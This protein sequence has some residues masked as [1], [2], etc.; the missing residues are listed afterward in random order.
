VLAL[1]AVPAAILGVS[2]AALG[3]EPLG[4]VCLAFALLL[5]VGAIWERRRYNRRIARGLPVSRRQA[6]AWTRRALER[7]LE[8][9][10]DVDAQSAAQA[11]LDNTEEP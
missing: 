10:A 3:S 4:G 11:A 1:E 9:P 5:A 2:A 7:L 8:N 6:L